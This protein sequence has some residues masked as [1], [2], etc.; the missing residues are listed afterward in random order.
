VP[1]ESSFVANCFSD[2][3]SNLLRSVSA[4]TLSVGERIYGLSRIWKD[5]SDMYSYW[6]L[7]PEDFSWDEA[8]IRL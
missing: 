6:E 8:I 2:T 1:T 5:T 4:I 7:L 3:L